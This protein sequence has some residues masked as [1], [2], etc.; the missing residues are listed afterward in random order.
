[1]I[2]RLRETISVK[3]ID[4]KVK[5]E[6]ILVEGKEVNTKNWYTFRIWECDKTK[7]NANG[8]T[9]HRVI[10]I[11]ESTFDCIIRTGSKVFRQIFAA[12]NKLPPR[13]IITFKTVY[14]TEC[15]ISIIIINS[16]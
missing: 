4:K 5:T 11:V 12:F 10:P 8:R 3:P 1:M 7:R 14:S 9:Y 15:R 13:I 6:K 2:Q 16:V